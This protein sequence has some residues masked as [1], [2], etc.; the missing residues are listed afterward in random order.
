MITLEHRLIVEGVDL[1]DAAAHKQGYDR[2]GARFKVRGLRQEWRIRDS[3]GTHATL[4]RGG[5]GRA[6]QSILTEE[7]GQR[8]AAY[9]AASLKQQVT[10]RDET[11]PASS[12]TLLFFHG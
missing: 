9:A 2:F 10:P 6:E 8:D 12:V 4:R 7:G 1:A 3:R 5:G 11:L